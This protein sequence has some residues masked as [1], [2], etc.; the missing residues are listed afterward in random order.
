MRKR[1]ANRTFVCSIPSPST[2]NSTRAN[3]SI[4]HATASTA[5][6]DPSIYHVSGCAP[7]HIKGVG[8]VG[9]CRA[10]WAYF[11]I[12]TCTRTHTSRRILQHAPGADQF[13][14]PHPGQELL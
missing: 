7:R 10:A 4:D 5:G 6:D 12:R 1:L 2:R 11:I 14:L 3:P 13:S 8:C 9:R